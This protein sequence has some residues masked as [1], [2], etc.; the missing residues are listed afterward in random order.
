VSMRNRFETASAVHALSVYSLPFYTK[1]DTVNFD[2]AFTSEIPGSPH[3]R[4]S[5]KCYPAKHHCE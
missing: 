3:L 1:H 4:P 2:V 5:H